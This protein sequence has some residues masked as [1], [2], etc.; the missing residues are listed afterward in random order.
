MFWIEIKGLPNCLECHCGLEFDWACL[1]WQVT[2]E[3]VERLHTTAV[4]CVGGSR[5]FRQEFHE[6]HETLSVSSYNGDLLHVL[7]YVV[8]EWRGA[9]STSVLHAVALTNVWEVGLTP[10]L[11]LHVVCSSPCF[12]W[13]FSRVTVVQSV[14]KEIED[15]PSDLRWRPTVGRRP[16]KPYREEMK[17]KTKTSHVSC[18][19]LIQR[20][21][22][23]WESEGTCTSRWILVGSYTTTS[24]NVPVAH[25]LAF[26]FQNGH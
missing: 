23:R 8:I 5:D 15:D 12:S 18:Y 24:R 14:S 11:C 25:V 1:S 7:P 16:E 20:L 6:W 26:D 10:K 22:G 3:D 21:I 2:D 13:T 17:A 19:W 9:P 4:D